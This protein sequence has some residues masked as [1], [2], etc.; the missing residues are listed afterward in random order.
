MNVPRF[1]EL[2]ERQGS[3]ENDTIKVYTDRLLMRIFTVPSL[4]TYL[5]DVMINDEGK[6][7]LIFYRIPD[8]FIDQV[9]N[10]IGK[11]GNVDIETLVFNSEQ[12]RA[13]TAFRITPKNVSDD[14]KN[15][16]IK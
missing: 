11:S 3:I 16:D 2:M 15:D 6:V 1:A 12:G 14:D 7:E 8:E 5:E 4:L 10:I 13:M 9:K